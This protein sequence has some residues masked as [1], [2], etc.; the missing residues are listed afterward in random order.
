MDVFNINPIPSWI[1]NI[2][3]LKILNANIAAVNLYGYSKD[4]FKNLHFNHLNHP[5][6]TRDISLFHPD[7]TGK[8]EKHYFG[9]FVHQKKSG[10]LLKIELNAQILNYK[11]QVCLL[12]VGNDITQND[13]QKLALKES[14]EQ[15]KAISSMAQIGY[16]RFHLDSNTISCT[17]EVFTIWDRK[18]E[19]F[20][21]NYKSFVKTIFHK[22]V[23]F[24]E[25]EKEISAKGIKPFDLVHRIIVPNKKIRWVHEFGRLVKDKKGKPIAFEGTVQNITQ[26]KEEEQKLKLIESVVTKTTDAVLIAEVAAFDEPGSCIIYVNEAFTKMTGYL[27]SEVIGKSPKMLHGSKSDKKELARLSKAIRNSEKCEITTINYRKNGDEFWVNF[28]VSPV[29]NEDGCYTH[30]IAIERD[31]TQQKNLEYEKEL[32]RNISSCFSEEAGFLEAAKRVSNEIGAYGNFD[33]VELWCPN[34]E[35]SQIQLVTKYT[36]RKK[37]LETVNSETFFKK[38]VGLPGMVW[39]KTKVLTWNEQKIST[40]FVRKKEA[41][42]LRLKALQGIPLKYK[43]KCIGVLLIGTSKDFSYLHKF[44]KVTQQLESFLGSEINRKRLENDMEH[45]YNTI[46]GILCVTDFEGRIFKMNKAGCELLGYPI[47]EILYKSF[48]EFAHPNDTGLIINQL[49]ALKKGA[50][51]YDFES[52]FITKQEKI[53]WLSWHCNSDLENKL[54]FASA[55][56]IVEE[57]RLK[58]LNVQAQKLAKIGSWE[59]NLQTSTVFWSKV[60]HQLH[61]TD[62]NTF[63]PTVETAINFYREDFRKMVA[64][65]VQKSIETGQEFDFEA[66]IITQSLKEKWIR[67]IGTAD[68]IYGLA[69]RVYGTFQDINEKKEYELRL[70][71]LT[72]SLPVVA[73]Q[74]LIYP[75]GTDTLRLIS[76]GSEKIWGF[77]QEEVAKDHYLVWNQIQLGGDIERVKNSIATSVQNKSKWSGR[78]RYVMPSGEKRVHK[79]YGTP[80]FL[81]DGTV[82]FTSLVLDVTQ[83]SKNEEQL[84][85]AN[86]RFEKVSAATNDAIY[87]WNIENESLYWGVSFYN[88]FGFSMDKTTPT[89]NF[90]TDN[91]HP[92]DL[93]KIEKNMY[94]ALENPSVTHLE[95]EYRFKKQDG[96]Y[97]FVI[98]KG[99]IIRDHD[100]K[101]VRMVGAIKDLTNQKTQ[102]LEL[103][104][105]NDS[106]K[107]YTLNLERSNEELEQFAFITSHDLQ[108]PLRMI[109]SFMELLKRKY[110]GQLDEKALEYIYYA[111]DGAK[112]MKQ[113]ILDLLHYSR[114]NKPTDEFEKVNL[115]EILYEFKQLR[116]KLIEEKAA[117][118]IADDLPVLKS[119]KALITQILHCLIDN[120]IK[121]SKENVPPII[122]INVTE[123]V[124]EWEFQIKDNGLGI[125]EKFF[126]KIFIIFQRLHNRE[127]FEGTGIGL[128]IVKRSVEFLG[129]KVWVTSTIG[130]GSTFYFTLPKN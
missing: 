118:I 22:D 80:K 113:I 64:A 91:I 41:G 5:K 78:W 39:E 120:A 61:E 38:G 108:E 11:D 45:I 51:N 106:L 8:L 36:K 42:K 88:L 96:T 95:G 97:A 43:N 23:N 1:Y 59:I 74:Y 65:N 33:L 85:E 26:Q 115:N 52:R 12:I 13:A 127:Q 89:L 34:L 56:N 60:V 79:G 110:E 129:G 44:S 105:L 50:L 126:D 68:M 69:K 24:F 17:D 111:T 58:E 15:L 83:E 109:T 93:Q 76:K 32:F 128:S 130:M 19:D 112:R 21:L 104:R 100:K 25:K 54:I 77:T 98:D 4:E 87:D 6:E 18:R 53:I 94:N 20:D 82:L 102:E 67:S 123:K 66:V 14:N 75:D 28:S 10:E 84:I 46:P 122:E 114:A 107:S 16:W 48:T 2:E 72:D 31:V 101:A 37:Y 90:W 124:K 119:Y 86:E 73:F 7:A 92:D 27:P 116:R 125:E 57:K 99:V 117:T 49:E 103:I 47:A 63:I 29:T 40:Y 121:Y 81:I 35:Q 71:S 30:W 70:Q 55:K 9:V 3:S 62:P